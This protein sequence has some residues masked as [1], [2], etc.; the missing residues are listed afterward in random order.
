MS[1]AGDFFKDLTKGLGDIAGGLFQA[2]G[3]AAVG[4]TVITG[5]K[6]ITGASA[7]EEANKEAK[8]QFESERKAAEQERENVQTA[9]ARDQLKASKLAASV[10]TGGRARTSSVGASKTSSLGGSDVQD[11]LG[12]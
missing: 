5:L 8:K 6:D 3:L 7:A 11:F 4:E 1:G 10:R 12:L 9:S 2:T